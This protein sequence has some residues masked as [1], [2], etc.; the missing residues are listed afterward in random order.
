MKLFPY[1]KRGT[2]CLL[3]VLKQK[4]LTMKLTV[5]LLTT[6][7]WANAS[8]LA[9]NVTLSV[10][11]EPI[12][13]VFN[14]IR[15]QTG[16]NFV[17]SD[18]V[19]T[20][21]Y[22]VT[23]N[24][25]DASLEDAMKKC[26]RG[27]PLSYSL[28]A[29][30]VVVK[31]AQTVTTIRS[32]QIQETPVSIIGVV[33]PGQQTQAQQGE[34]DTLIDVHGKIVD[35][36]GNPLP[37][38][39]VMTNWPSKG[40]RV[41]SD[42]AGYFTLNSARA[43]GQIS[44][45]KLGFVLD[46]FDIANN[47]TP[48]FSLQKTTA[49]NKTLDEVVV[50]GY[51]SLS[52][53]TAPI[54]VSSVDNKELNRKINPDLM[55][56]LEGKLPGLS[57][58]QNKMVARGQSTFSGSIG[59][60]PLIVIDG[61]PSETVA[62]S[63]F[64][65]PP[66]PS[67]SNTL[68]NNLSS[69]INPN[70]VESVTLLKDAA[71]T[72][73]YG[74]R[75]TNGV[76]VITTKSG[77]GMG[78]NRITVQFSADM[79]VTEKPN[80][81]QMHYASTSDLIDYETALY[82]KGV[83]TLGLGDPATYF[84]TMGYIGSASNVS[85]YSPLVNLYRL[86]SIG[87]IS[88]GDLDKQIATMRT[89]DSRKQFADLAWRNAL[90]QSYNLSVG[91]SN[92][93]QDV[94]FSLNYVGQKDKLI[95]NDGQAFNLY[96]KAGQ[97]ISKGVNV[98]VGIN[99][100]YSLSN[101]VNDGSYTS[102]T[103]FLEPYNA[104]VDASGKRVYTPY[105][106][107]SDAFGSLGATAINGRTAAQIDSINML[108]AGRLKSF[109]YNT[110]DELA[111]NNSKLDKLGIRAFAN[112]DAKLYKGLTYTSTFQYEIAKSKMDYV[113][114]EDAYKMRFMVN[115]MA[116]NSGTGNPI[117]DPTVTL[118]YPISASGGRLQ[119]ASTATNNYTWRNQLNFNK[120]FSN[121]HNINLL[122]G[123]E[124]RQTYSPQSV[125]AVYYGY[126]PVT[127]NTVPF[128]QATMYNTGVTSYIW[129]KSSSKQRV[130]NPVSLNSY[131]PTKH[132]FF[133]MYGTGSYT[134]KN[135]YSF[136]GSVR[137]DQADFFGVD[138]KYRYRPLWSVGGGWLLSNEN[139]LKG[140]AKWLDLLKIRASYGLTG[141]VDQT[142]SPYV[143]ASGGTNSLYQP[144]LDYNFIGS[145]PN[146][147]LRWE[148]TSTYNAGIDYAMFNNR[149]RGT[150]DMYYKLGT[151]LLA[152]KTLDA[153]NGF[154]SAK[155]NNGA[156]TNRGV[157][158]SVTGDL[159]RTKNWL[160]TSM[161]TFA[162]NKN[163]VT[164]IA[165]AVTNPDQLISSSSYYLT[166]NPISSI[167]AYRYAGLSTGGNDEQNGL[168]LIYTDASMKN[169]E[170][171]NSGTTTTVAQSSS[172]NVNAAKYM[173]SAVPVWN[174][175]FQQSV[176]FKGIELNVLFVAYGGYK[177][178]KD[179]VDLYTGSIGGG[180]IDMDIAKRWTPQN[181]NTNIPKTLPDYSQGQGASVLYLNNYWKQADVQVV[182]ANY[183]RL[184][185]ITLGYNL[186]QGIARKLYTQ[187]VKLSAQVNNSWF[188]F[189]AKDDIDPDTFSG[190]GSAGTRSY[191][192]PVS[193]LF[194]LDVTL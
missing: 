91:S 51:Q 151:D 68:A 102:P 106:N 40:K 9:Q 118:T 179:A 135:L 160:V 141:N 184:R 44:I 159:V 117:T 128:D 72:A 19:A 140:T 95:S 130:S 75:A 79:I 48:I 166:G 69:I 113:V 39:L 190:A 15:K 38:A 94:Y 158:V 162:Y 45:S 139:F 43:N 18:D 80:L 169:V 122:A 25:R 22:P 97:K 86:Q 189:S 87:K 31:Y 96:L 4:M 193:Y 54:A 167:Y 192:T 92:D 191:Q 136:F 144:L 81:D 150:V 57:M 180:A 186:P 183:I 14:A 46:V 66:T 93:K 71:A 153:T 24:V 98:S 103:A 17:Y 134:F 148:K 12:V 188:W 131:A 61:V 23:M 52:K 89:I 50:T 78:K 49:N 27:Q 5:L 109:G 35:A 85:Y 181:P 62:L 119:Q 82:K 7:L 10:K 16:Y 143:V 170:V 174:G 161:A 67:T 73:V 1:A 64:D 60:R 11:G 168:P 56:A 173:G 116:Y 187:N 146:P 59:T 55:S 108:K 171:A 176:A 172:F 74:A 29:K 164:K 154:A 185:N 120:S 101:Q 123:T 155:V 104:I 70:D 13:K 147:L 47:P 175:S 133:S 76:L 107:L 2:G 20:K 34:T 32:K 156:M 126:N 42:N 88:Q 36:D 90:R 132:R 177:I 142:S 28:V 100:Q 152:T 124:V 83:A 30:T 77:R 6:V 121:I 53:A 84:N 65:A 165:L 21:S 157:E 129:S 105:V 127:L 125:D 163:K 111:R 178:R 138:P 137:V 110:L 99:T 145:A 112:I 149:L 3:P 41:Q 63:G 114:E 194:R 8:G 115:R 182:S 37:G 26:M 58:F 33:D